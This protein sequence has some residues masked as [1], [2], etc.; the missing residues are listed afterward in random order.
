MLSSADR[1]LAVFFQLSLPGEMNEN[2]EVSH[3]SAK[4]KKTSLSVVLI[5]KKLLLLTRHSG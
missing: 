5:P 2:K 1:R 4:S 3:S